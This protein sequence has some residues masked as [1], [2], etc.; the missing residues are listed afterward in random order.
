MQNGKIG[1]Y[2]VVFMRGYLNEASSIVE[3]DFSN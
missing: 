2:A 3:T 1:T